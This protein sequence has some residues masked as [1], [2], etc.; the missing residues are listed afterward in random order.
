M[1]VFCSSDEEMTNTNA[2][3]IPL[4]GPKQCAWGKP[5]CFTI[6]YSLHYKERKGMDNVKGINGFLKR[7]PAIDQS[8]NWLRIG[9][10][11]Y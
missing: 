2:C 5:K 1:S 6:P 3:F 8:K 7:A 4:L 9:L 10:V 11:I